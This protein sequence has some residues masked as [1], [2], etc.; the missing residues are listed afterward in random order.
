M[1]P[2]G[3][4]GLALLLLRLSVAIALVLHDYGYR[5]AVPDWVHAAVILISLF[6]SVGYLTPVAACAALVCHTVIWF[7]LGAGLD[8]A[9]FTLLFAIDALALALLGPGAYSLDS[10][11]FG[12]RLVVLPPA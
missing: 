11:R 7:A 1:F 5:D 3:W 10:R 2:R 4:P 9:S 6:V 12:R 8:T